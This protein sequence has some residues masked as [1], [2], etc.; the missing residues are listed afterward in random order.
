LEF[1]AFPPT[2]TGIHSSANNDVLEACPCFPK[3]SH[4]PE[5][6]QQVKNYLKKEETLRYRKNRN[7]LKWKGTWFRGRELTEFHL[8]WICTFNVWD[9]GQSTFNKY[10]IFIHRDKE[11]NS[12]L[13]QYLIKKRVLPDSEA[14][15]L[16]ISH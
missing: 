3:Q 2:S 10:N 7:S 5:T 13:I 16:F 4:L 14:H 12:W 6:A 1:E 9:N 8:I 11:T 15:A